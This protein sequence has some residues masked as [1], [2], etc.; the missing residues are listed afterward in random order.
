MCVI[1]TPVLVGEPK[2][3]WGS[4]L[5]AS[6]IKSR[7]LLVVMSVMFVAYGGVTPWPA[8]LATGD[9]P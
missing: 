3:L 4:V 5:N 9:L 8:V 1:L 6:M 7:G 2:E